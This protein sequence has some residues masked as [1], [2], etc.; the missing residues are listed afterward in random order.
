LG[1][2]SSPPRPTGSSERIGSKSRLRA[3][4]RKPPFQSTVDFQMV[5]ALFGSSWIAVTRSPTAA[6]FTELRVLRVVVILMS[7]VMSARERAGNMC[8]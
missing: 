4:E 7:F 2:V 6:I 1:A 5:P 3:S 8:S